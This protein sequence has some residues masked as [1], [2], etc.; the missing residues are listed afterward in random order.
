MPPPAPAAS[1]R[2]RAGRRPSWQSRPLGYHP[3]LDG[4][5]ALAVALVVAYHLGYAG[6]AGGYIGVEVFFVLSGW[7]VCAM[8]VNEHHRTGRIRLGHFWLRRARR[9]LPALIATIAGTVAVAS[10]VQPERLAELRTQGAAALAYHLNWRLILD[11]ESYFEA[12]NGPSALE[13]LWSLSIEEQFYLV[14][15]L[16][17]GLLLVR[18]TRQRAVALVLGGALV[19]T[20]LRLL[21]VDPGGD[22]SRAYFGTDTRAS[23]LLLGVAVGLFWTPNRLRPHTDARFVAALDVVAVA[24]AA[25]LAW[26]ACGLDERAP[27]AFRGGFTAAQLAS[28]A[29]IAVVVYPAPT[30]TVALLSARPLRW[31]G[32]RS[33]GIYLV[34]WPVIV[35]LSSA[36]GEQPEGPV[37]VAAQVALIL[38]L[39]ALSYRVVE[40]PIRRHGVVASA[41]AAAGHVAALLDGRPMA[42]LTVAT[43]CVVAFGAT[44]GVTRDVVTASSPEPAQPDSVVIAVPTTAPAPAQAPVGQAPAPTT[45]TAA[46]AAAPP[47][48][49]PPAGASY[50]ST[51]A[52]GDSVLVG[53][54][55]AMAARMGPALAVDAAVGRQMIDADKLIADL[56]SRGQLGQ[57]VLLHL[58]NNGP[59]S[60]AQLDAVFAAIGPERT[61]LLVNVLVPR[62]WEG[63]VNDQLAAAAARHPNAVLLDWRALVTA[64]SGLTRDDGFHLTPNGA[65]RYADLV[66]GQ[67]PPA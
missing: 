65:E 63:E 58:G 16:V 3:A 42:A 10:M 1:R 51:T 4:V 17:C 43:V 47:P 18:R 7:L 67:V 20:A 23:G 56:S 11:R 53:A 6:V 45:T 2:R 13:H 24:A 60:A 8:L 9:L 37:A 5:R 49:P 55:P 27:T 35:F 50:A 46:T 31:I 15:P 61:V 52:I 41:R 28:L 36:P 26:Y 19:A 64:E 59:F 14:F 38:G 25:V 22:P 39:A 54:A 32:Q 21:F 33:Y 66:V 62:R 12:A 48:P 40:Q 30:R 57:V 44:I 34:H 29:L